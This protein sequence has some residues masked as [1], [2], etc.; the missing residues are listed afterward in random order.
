VD[1]TVTLTA[2]LQWLARID[3]REALA[4]LVGLFVD[5]GVAEEAFEIRDINWDQA[6]RARSVVLADGRTIPLRSVALIIDAPDARLTAAVEA[7]LSP[8]ER[9]TRDRRRELGQKLAALGFMESL[10]SDE[11]AGH[12]LALVD[13][14]SAGATSSYEL[15][16]AAYLAITRGDRKVLCRAGARLFR[17]L[18]EREATARGVIPEDCYWRLVKMLNVAGELQEA[19]AL[20]EMLWNGQVRGQV[21]LRLLATT[22]AAAQLAFAEVTH[23]AGRL[24]AAHRACRLAWRLAPGDDVTSHMFE[25]VRGAMRRAGIDW[26]KTRKS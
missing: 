20:D 2:V 11:D 14:M 21:D 15:R 7:A 22:L 6:G 19:V 18:M 3:R 26:D 1:R 16:Q 9:A 12:V 24:R 23:D 13:T 25:A 4:V 10:A 17:Q 5:D 8:G